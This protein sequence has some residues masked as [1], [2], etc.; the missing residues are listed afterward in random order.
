[1]CLIVL[2]IG[3]SGVILGVFGVYLLFYLR[4]WVLV[5]VLFGFLLYTMCLSVGIVLV[6]WF[7]M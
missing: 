4:V 3:V 2:M 5:V 7:V 1:M 6:I